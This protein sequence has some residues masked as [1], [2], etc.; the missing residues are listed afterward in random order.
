[1]SKHFIREFDPE[2]RIVASSFQ[3]TTDPSRIFFGHL[4]FKNGQEVYAKVNLFD[5]APL[6]DWLSS[7]E[8]ISVPVKRPTNW[9][10]IGGAAF[11]FLGVA[12]LVKLLYSH[13]AAILHSKHTW[14][15][16]ALVEILMMISGHMWN[17]IRK[18]PY[19]IG[20][21]QGG[22]SYIAQGYQNQI[23]LESQIVAVMCE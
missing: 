14:A 13:L 11:A 17:H 4:D 21:N 23:G 12:A 6:A 19:V 5:A 9:F 1:H 22:I 8:G 16:V 2:F 10:A 3:R 20:N 7:V 18:P 15:A